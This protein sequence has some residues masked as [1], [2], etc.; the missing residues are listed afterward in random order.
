MLTAPVAS[1]VQSLRDEF[2]RDMQ[3]PNVLK[4]LETY[5]AEREDWKDFAVF[6]PDGQRYS[7]NLIERNDMF[8]LLVLCWGPG[9]ESPVHNHE[10]QNCWMAILEGAIE[11]VYYHFPDGPGPL[12]RKGEVERSDAGE[13]GYIS[14]E[15]A[16]HLIRPAGS[17]RA[18]SLHLY[19]RPFDQCNLYCPET[20]S[21]ERCRLGY[22]SVRGALATV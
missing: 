9:Q 18:V 10:G 7:R 3:G 8:E 5:V 14:D 6:R 21:V 15:V 17:E 22:Y 1:L 2:S 19:S 16:L 12:R 13:T 20:G 11:E 4:M